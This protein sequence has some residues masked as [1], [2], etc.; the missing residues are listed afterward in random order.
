MTFSS[1]SIAQSKAQQDWTYGRKLSGRP[2]HIDTRRKNVH[3]G[4]IVAE[5][6]SG[7]GYVGGADC[8]GSWGACGGPVR[9]IVVFVAGCC[10][11]VDALSYELGVVYVVSGRI[12]V[13]KGKTYSFDSV[14]VRVGDA[15]SQDGHG[16][17]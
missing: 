14:I 4:P 8:D 5:P 7:V 11:D 13:V 12:W 1:I 6:S 9:C 3:D 17:N 10:D 16:D 2:S 15:K